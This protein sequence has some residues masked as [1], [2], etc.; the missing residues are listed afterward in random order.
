[1]Q[2]PPVLGFVGNFIFTFIATD[3]ELTVTEPQ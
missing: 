1:V 3:L 2:L